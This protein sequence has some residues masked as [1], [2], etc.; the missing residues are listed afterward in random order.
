M[1]GL[2]P[3]RRERPAG[4][5]LP[6]AHPLALARRELDTLF[7]RLFG[8]WPLELPEMLEYPVAW[9]MKSEETEKE[10]IIRVEAPG[11]ELTDFDVE[12]LGDVLTVVA[13][14][15]VA[16]GKEGEKTEE[17][18]T[19]LK[20]YVTL[21]PGVDPTGIEAFY[22]SGILEIHLPKKPE[23]RGRKIEVKI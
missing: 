21:P 5:L 12:V 16:K 22:R 13:T 20:R 7:D 14:R 3:W 2:M 10:V 17:R 4:T 19:E 8:R 1:F 6:E 18:V 11:F 23:A 9:G 15:K